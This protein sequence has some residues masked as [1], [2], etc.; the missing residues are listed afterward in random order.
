[1]RYITGHRLMDEHLGGG[2]SLP[3]I[4]Y[5]NARW[6][7]CGG[8]ISMTERSCGVPISKVELHISDRC[9]HYNG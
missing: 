7:G 5:W 1:M 2:V 4:A 8:A 3:Q 6:N 9:S